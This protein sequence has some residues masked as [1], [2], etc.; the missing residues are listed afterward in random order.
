VTRDP[1]SRDSV[2][3]V[4]PRR[5]RLSLRVLMLLVLAIAGGL[6]W[7]T[8][9]ATVRRELSGLITRSGC[10]VYYDWQQVSRSA[11]SGVR[12]PWLRRM[13]GPGY[14][15]DVIGVS[16]NRVVDDSLMPEI[17]RLGGLEWLD[18]EDTHVTDRGLAHISNLKSLKRLELSSSKV[19]GVGKKRG[20]GRKGVRTI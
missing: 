10:I 8:Y 5:F 16:A 12:Q 7:M 6:R 13:L 19:T 15:E 14:F 11:R 9:K 17:S 3:E 4:R 1:V 20:Q 2:P 18:L